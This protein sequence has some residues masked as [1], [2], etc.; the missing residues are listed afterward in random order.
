M[1]FD[2]KIDNGRVK[3]LVKRVRVNREI[4]ETINKKQRIDV[5]EKQLRSQNEGK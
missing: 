3:D 2:H 5:A 1:K 4:L